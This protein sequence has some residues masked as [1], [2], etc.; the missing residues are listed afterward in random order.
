MSTFCKDFPEEGSARTFN[1]IEPLIIIQAEFKD[2]PYWTVILGSI[3]GKIEFDAV[4]GEASQSLEEKEVYC[5]ILL[6]NQ[7]LE[8]DRAVVKSKVFVYG[9][10]LRTIASFRSQSPIILNIIQAQNE[11]FG[12]FRRHVMLT[13]RRK[14]FS[15]QPF[16]I[17]SF[18]KLA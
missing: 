13:I 11:F 16:S 6:A 18:A 2:V 1:P 5:T 17:Q 4:C 7:C 9:P 15:I 14:F 8:F 12:D 3:Y 10:Q